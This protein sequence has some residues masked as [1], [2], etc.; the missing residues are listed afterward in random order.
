M[1]IARSMPIVLASVSALLASTFLEWGLINDMA[2]L[3]WSIPSATAH[4]K[5]LFIIESSRDIVV[6]DVPSYVLAIAA[7]P[8]LESRE[9]CGHQNMGECVC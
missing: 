4:V 1:L 6:L 2:G 8:L 9:G 5:T 3:V 7:I